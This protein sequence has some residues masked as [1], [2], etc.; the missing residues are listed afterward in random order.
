MSA[1]APMLPL[2]DVLDAAE[3]AR[4]YQERVE[5]HRRSMRACWPEWEGPRVEESVHGRCSVGQCIVFS[6]THGENLYLYTA[7]CRILEVGPG[8][9]W[10]RAVV[11]YP[12]DA[13]SWV[14]HH[15]GTVVRMDITEVWPPTDELWALRRAEEVAE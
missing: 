13:A 9:E 1:E 5:A 7:P 8:M 15:N 3:K 11:D 4:R 14:L 2:F 12:P 6:E 10:V